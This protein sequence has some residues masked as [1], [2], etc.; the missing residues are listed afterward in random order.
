MHEKTKNSYYLLDRMIQH[1]LEV[2]PDASVRMRNLTLFGIRG[3]YTGADCAFFVH[4]KPVLNAFRHQ[5]NLHR[6]HFVYRHYN[7]I[8]HIFHACLTDIR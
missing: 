6:L 2:R 8:C 5:R 3:I 7:K 1:I 4:N